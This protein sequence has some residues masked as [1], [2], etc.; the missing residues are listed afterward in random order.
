VAQETVLPCGRTKAFAC[1]LLSTT[2]YNNG[3]SVYYSNGSDRRV[4]DCD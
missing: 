1:F 4:Y 2:K 3:A